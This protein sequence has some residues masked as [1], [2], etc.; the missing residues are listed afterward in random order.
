MSI[1]PRGTPIIS[2]DKYG[3]IDL[4]HDRCNIKHIEHVSHKLN[5]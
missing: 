5:N 2:S 3:Y 4:K 1:L